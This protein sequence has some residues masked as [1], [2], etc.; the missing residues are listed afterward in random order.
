MQAAERLAW[1]DGRRKGIGG[2]EVA[3]VVE[4][5][6]RR[7]GRWKYADDHH[8]NKW[9]TAEGLLADKRGEVPHG[10]TTPRLEIGQLMEH[11][12]ALEYR[13]I[14]GLDV[15]TDRGCE[16]DSDAYDWAQGNID[17]WLPDED[18]EKAKIWECKTTAPW[19]FRNGWKGEVPVYI[20]LQCQYYMML[21]ATLACD[22]LVL[23]A[24]W[25]NWEQF[26]DHMAKAVQIDP[27]LGWKADAYWMATKEKAAVLPVEANP[28]WWEKTLIAAWDGFW[29]GVKDG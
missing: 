9:Q 20:Q 21:T 3:T 28:D 18:G 25:R 11:M 29:Q 4:W 26:R 12:G 17:G 7:E 10:E 1:L 22:V 24:D 23:V 5:Y 16:L 8:L 15:I 6:L 27:A 19:Y 14:T 13:E 2:S